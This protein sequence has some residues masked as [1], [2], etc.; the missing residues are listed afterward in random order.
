MYNWSPKAE[1]QISNRK[2]GLIRMVVSKSEIFAGI[3]LWKKNLR[4]APAYFSCGEISPANVFLQTLRQEVRRTERSGR[5]FALALIRS[6]GFGDKTAGRIV[7][8]LSAAI[9]ASIRETDSLGWY[10]Q[11]ET[12]GIVLTEIGEAND[13]KLELLAQKISHA[14]QRAVSEREFN[15]LS[16]S[17]RFV[18]QHTSKSADVRWERDIYRDLHREQG[19][20][21]PAEIVKRAIDLLGSLIALIVLLPAFALVVA[22]VK[23]TSRGPVFYCQERVGQYGR[24]FKF[25]KFRS[26]YVNND[27]GLHRDYVTKLIEGAKHVQ[28]PNGMYKLVNDPRVTRV[29]RFLR[30]SSLDELPQ[31]FNI[32]RGDMSLVG[33][34]PPL[35]YE[36]ERYRVWHRRRVLDIKPGLTGLWQVKGRSRTTFDEMVRMDLRYARTRSLWMDI[37]IILQTPVAMFSGTGAS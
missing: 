9:L 12:L 8:S 33:P 23:L 16:L 25:Y 15:R 35:P 21:I 32:L 4:G 24:L 14:M 11:N 5:P 26:M 2:V 3:G 30:R 29:G 27:S 28:Q 22:L 6:E 37:K 18:P 34:R 19:P 31:F 20:E 17:V 13:A 10:E 36:F 7:H 1:T